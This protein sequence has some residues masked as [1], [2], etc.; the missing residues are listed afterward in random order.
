MSFTDA[1]IVIDGFKNRK[2]TGEKPFV[3][4]C[5]DNVRY[6]LETIMSKTNPGFELEFRLNNLKWKDPKN[7]YAGNNVLSK[8]KKTEIRITN[9]AKDIDKII[10]IDDIVN[11]GKGSYEDVQYE[12]VHREFNLLDRNTNE[13]A[14]VNIKNHYNNND[15]LY[16]SYKIKVK[17][18][19]PTPDTYSVYLV[20]FSIDE[21][22][23]F[24]KKVIKLTR[25]RHKPTD[26]KTFGFHLRE[27]VSDPDDMITYLYDNKNY[28]PI[29][30][31]MSPK[32][33]VIEASCEPNLH[34]WNDAFFMP[35]SCMLKDNYEV[36]YYLSETSENLKKNGGNSDI[37]NESYQGNAMME[38]SNNGKPFYWSY[39]PDEDGRGAVFT[40]STHK[41]NEKMDAWNFYDKLGDLKN[42]FY[43]NKYLL[44]K[45]NGKYRSL[46]TPISGLGNFNNIIYES[47]FEYNN[48]NIVVERLCDYQL[49]LLLSMMVCKSVNIPKH[50]GYGYTN[51]NDY[52]YTNLRDMQKE[53]R[54][55]KLF[56]GAIYYKGVPATERMV[57]PG[58]KI[59]GMYNWYGLVPKRIIGLQ[60]T[61]VGLVGKLCYGYNDGSTAH[62]MLDSGQGMCVI[63]RG[64][65]KTDNSIYTSN[66]VEKMN[67][68]KFGL[69]PFF[70]EYK[71]MYNRASSS[72]YYCE[73]NRFFFY[74]PIKDEII[75]NSNGKIKNNAVFYG[76]SIKAESNKGMRHT[77]ALKETT[78]LLRNDLPWTDTNFNSFV[79][80]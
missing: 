26:I 16:V 68:S 17:K 54:T 8:W 74:K 43:T 63:N 15:G 24:S 11:F 42:A 55:K 31:I 58:V 20:I 12:V 70:K 61:N 45:I 28:K 37:E 51:Y 38:W 36:D 50:L 39:V 65:Y 30:L 29:E 46:D 78:V 73:L 79:I 7:I 69:T 53:F 23:M 76:N 21:N 9:N 10:D 48:S 62:S 25:I 71:D 77:D 6:D 44:R 49:V 33:A 14:L 3:I 40:I 13:Y 32:K 66:Y 27:D 41:L 47:L 64:F 34:E 57:Y 19:V 59:F 4:G 2:I 1:E 80:I 60:M 52:D 67:H 56:A 18:D 5:A 35:K 75:S 72:T 22:D